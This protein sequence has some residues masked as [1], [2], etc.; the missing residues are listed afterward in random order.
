MNESPEAL[1]P[2]AEAFFL[3][4]PG[5]SY[6][7][8]LV[9]KYPRIANQI[10]KLKD[11]KEGLR[12]YFDELTHDRRGGRHGFPFEVLMDINNLREQILGDLTG[13]TLDDSTKWVS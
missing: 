10:V 3:Q 2:A 5:L 7:K 1:S 12:T 4:T 11:D 8:A 13:F 9:K 6:P